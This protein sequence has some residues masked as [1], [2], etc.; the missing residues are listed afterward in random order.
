[1]SGVALHVTTA[2]GLLMVDV[3][4]TRPAARTSVDICAV[5]DVSGSMGVEANMKDER[6][7]EIKDGLT[8]LDVVKHALRTIAHSLGESDTFSLVAF[9]TVAR[10]V[11]AA[12]VMGEEG[13]EKALRGIDSLRAAGQT[14]LWDGISSGLD[15]LKSVE[16]ASRVQAC[17]LL[18]DGQPNIVPPTGHIPMLR[19]KMRKSEHAVPVHTF[20]FGREVE[21]VLLDEIAEETGGLYAYIPDASLVGSVF[22]STLAN[23][24]TTLATAATLRVE[25]EE[26]AVEIKLGMLHQEQTRTVVLAASDASRVT[27]Q[28][29]SD[30]ILAPLPVSS[31]E[32]RLRAESARQKAAETIRRCVELGLTNRLLEAQSAVRIAVLDADADPGL[33]FDL[34]GQVA[35]AVSTSAHFQRWGRHYLPSLAAAHAHQVSNNCKDPGVQ[36]YGGPMFRRLREDFEDIFCKLPPPTPSYVLQPAVRAIVDM[37]MYIDNS[38]GSCFEGGGLLEM[39]DGT[40]KRVDGVRPRDVVLGGHTVVCVVRTVIDCTLTRIGALLVTDWHPIGVGGE[41]VFP[42]TVP[43]ATRASARAV[44]N[45]VLDNGHEVTIEGTACVTLGHGFAGPVVSHAYFGTKKVV[46]DL[47]AMRGWAE[48]YV[49]VAGALRNAQ[50]LVCGLLE[51]PL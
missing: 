5:V 48:G 32:P 26:R 45:F 4:P 25:H 37:S 42:C 33:L 51:S 14:N 30:V 34:Q 13:K 28:Y 41:W 24:C 11:V 2:D 23:L 20:G 6:G 7:A 18:T 29:G 39:H 35:E 3:S 15:A 38:R 49:S 36:V 16:D 12:V 1:M 46:L 19:R 27:L 50:G 9:S 17:L 8:V 47:C 10:V 21:S 44:Y 43:G 40:R 22:V 31:A